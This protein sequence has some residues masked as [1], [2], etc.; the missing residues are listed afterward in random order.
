MQSFYY[1]SLKDAQEQIVQ[2]AVQG[3]IINGI[4]ACTIKF[5][6]ES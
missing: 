1:L 5:H 4:D 2:V 3:K 6:L